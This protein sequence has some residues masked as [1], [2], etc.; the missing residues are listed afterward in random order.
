MPPSPSSN[1]SKSSSGNDDSKAVGGKM[2]AKWCSR[3]DVGVYLLNG[4]I[5]H[6]ASVSW[7]QTPRGTIESCGMIAGMASRS[8]SE[9]PAL[10][11]VAFIARMKSHIIPAVRQCTCPAVHRKKATNGRAWG[12]ICKFARLH[13]APQ[14]TGPSDYRKPDDQRSEHSEHPNCIK[15]YVRPSGHD[16]TSNQGFSWIFAVT[17]GS[18]RR[19]DSLSHT[20]VSCAIMNVFWIH[21]QEAKVLSVRF[22]K[23]Y[24]HINLAA[25]HPKLCT[26]FIQNSVY[27]WWFNAYIHTCIHTYMH[28]CM[29]ATMHACIHIRKSWHGC[30]MRRVPSKTTKLGETL[31]KCLKE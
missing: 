29:H 27:L 13:T 4:R 31:E 8:A 30:G 10:T 15:T 7:V 19:S 11:V 22:P 26:Y 3:G 14:N 12:R 18:G 25:K 24:D 23:E 5:G 1:K 20:F 17:Q 2:V 21:I 9:Y 28:A 6:I 16:E